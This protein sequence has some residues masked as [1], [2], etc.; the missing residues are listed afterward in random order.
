MKNS[1]LRH[2]FATQFLKLPDIKGLD[3][4]HRDTEVSSAREQLFPVCFRKTHKGFQRIHS[5]GNKKKNN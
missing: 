5:T 3:H 4:I 2:S 1:H